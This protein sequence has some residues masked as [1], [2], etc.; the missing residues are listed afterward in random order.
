MIHYSFKTWT[1]EYPV[2]LK[3]D[4]GGGGEYNTVCEVN[5][6]SFFFINRGY[7]KPLYHIMC[8]K[9]IIGDTNV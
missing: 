7:Y 5:M 3:L 9:Q 6:D 2:V 4:N 1:L 8:F